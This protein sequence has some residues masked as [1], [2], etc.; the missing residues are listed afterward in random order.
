MALTHDSA[1]EQCQSLFR[2]F[3]F[4]FILYPLL[5]QSIFVWARFSM[6]QL[7]QL[8]PFFFCRFLKHFRKMWNSNNVGKSSISYYSKVIFF[9]LL[10][11]YK[12]IHR[13]VYALLQ[14]F[15]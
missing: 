15:I 11:V 14:T 12:D 4:I 13:E 6:K 1:P 10:A 8:F 5:C 9:L 3:I 2:I 7:L